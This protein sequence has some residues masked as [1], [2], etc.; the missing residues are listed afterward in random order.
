MAIERIQGTDGIRGPTCLSENSSSQSPIE[1]FLDEGVLTEEFFE[2]YTYSFCRELLDT[3]FAVNNDIAVIGWDPRDSSGRFNKAAVNGI[4]KAGMTAA[5][6]D[7]LPTPAISMY[8]LKI[9]AA[10]GI[11][12]TASH[13]REDQ[14]GIKIFLGHS[15]LKLFPEDDKR[16][17]H[18]CL[19]LNYEEIRSIPLAGGINKEHRQAKE[20][21]VD[22]ISDPFNNWLRKRL[23]NQVTVI[24]DAANG[25]FSYIVKDLLDYEGCRFEF[26]NCEPSRGIN[27]CSG[28]ADLEG[29]SVINADEILEGAFGEYEALG[30]ILS[31]GR[32]QNISNQNRPGMVFGFV[33]DG[34]GDRCFL[35][36]Y[37]AHKDHVKV[38]GGDV[39]AFLQAKILKH[40]SKW[41]KPPLYLN[42]VES[43]IESEL[44]ARR[45][46][47]ETKQCAVGDKW[48]LWESFLSQWNCR[49]QYYLEKVDDAEFKGLI[50]QTDRKLEQMKNSRSFDA[51]S[52]T[53]SVFCIEKW[54]IGKKR[55][56]LINLANS[57][58]C[59]V[60][61]NFFAIGSEE[62]GHLITLG[63]IRFGD[64]FMPVFIGNGIKCA[65]NS[66]AAVLQLT[67]NIKQDQYSEKLTNP[68]PSGYQKNLQVYYVDKSLLCEGSLMRKK[69]QGLLLEN[70]NWPRM[71][72]KIAQNQQEPQ[73]LMIRVFQQK[74]PVAI[75]YVRNSGTEDKLAL[76]LRG[77]TKFTKNL[78]SLAKKVYSYLMIHFKNKNSLMAIAENSILNSLKDESRHT[79]I[80]EGPEFEKV[81]VDRLLHEMSSRQKL[82]EKYKG[83]WRVTDL[84]RT[85][86]NHSEHSECI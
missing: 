72:I 15:N 31:I 21:F 23:F 7:I 68:Y 49:K 54:L 63:K 71:E 52:A 40:K 79:I 29:I 34:D 4:R 32:K 26:L 43:D 5:V 16:L 84:G 19:S 80:L 70:L 58:A 57:H 37:D 6:V 10:C 59:E 18:R 17:T 82:I 3:G 36:Y 22:F 25:A 24:V 14:N 85:L 53:N 73:M 2:L 28:V 55:D 66:I 61:N 39:Q 13:N 11:V 38:L 33:F 8:Q 47:F 45:E 56:E 27:S 20:L 41:N 42:T 1:A 78:D 9:G 62:S 83:M 35:L 64:M 50:I 81:P 12:L 75:V 60:S 76:Y 44:A 86:V 77:S 65:L 74:L 30:R 46:G 67:P 48:I 69:L 51:I